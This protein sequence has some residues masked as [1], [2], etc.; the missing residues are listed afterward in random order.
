M[1]TETES[2]TAFAPTHK[3][4]KQKEGRKAEG[5][6]DRVGFDC[7]LLCGLPPSDSSPSAL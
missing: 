1:K 4:R 7:L 2:L 3:L 5:S 6:Q